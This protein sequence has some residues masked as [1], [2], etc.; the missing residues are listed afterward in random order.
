MIFLSMI[1]DLSFL[2]NAFVSRYFKKSFSYRL[3][4]NNAFGASLA[5]VGAAVDADEV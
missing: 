2:N 5:T 1:S 3:P 4:E